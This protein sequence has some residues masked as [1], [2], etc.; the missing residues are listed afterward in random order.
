MFSQKAGGQHVEDPHGPA[1]KAADKDLP[2]GMVGNGGGT[3]LGGAEVVQ[4]LQSLGIPH[5]DGVVT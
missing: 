3:L 4:L 5:P 1:L 2:A